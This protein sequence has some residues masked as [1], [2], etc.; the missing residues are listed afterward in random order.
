MKQILIIFFFFFFGHIYSQKIISLDSLL[1]SYINNSLSCNGKCKLYFIRDSI[2]FN[3]LSNSQLKGKLISS[4]DKTTIK[5]RKGK[6]C[7]AQLS[8]TNKKI[9]DGS[10]IMEINYD[11]NRY[12]KANKGDVIW[13]SEGVYKFKIWRDF[14]TN[15]LLKLEFINGI[16]P[17]TIFPK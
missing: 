10:I 11:A 8:A 12:I 17:V 7:V 13:R 4:S 5:K 3:D 1:Y 9:I 15:A 2:I 16:N 6:V 14:S